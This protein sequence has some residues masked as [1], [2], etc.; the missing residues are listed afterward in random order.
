MTDRFKTVTHWCHKADNDLKAAN[1]EIDHEDGA[2]DTVCFHA[3][4]TV[5]KYLKAYLVF[6]GKE[7]PEEGLYRLEYG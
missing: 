3:Q 4:Q 7:G 1:H 2:F 5:E 6:H